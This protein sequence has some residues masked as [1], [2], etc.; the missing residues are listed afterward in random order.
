[1][2]IRTRPGK[3]KNESFIAS[4]ASSVALHVVINTGCDIAL[5]SQMIMRAHEG[6]KARYTFTREKRVDVVVHESNYTR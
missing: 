1:M 5:V 4:K 3:K 2:K 6:N